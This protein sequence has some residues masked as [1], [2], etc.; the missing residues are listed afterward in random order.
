MCKMPT[1][2]LTPVRVGTQETTTSTHVKKGTPPVR[3]LAHIAQE[4]TY[5]Y[6]GQ[7]GKQQSTVTSGRVKKKPPRYADNRQPEKV[8]STTL[9]YCTLYL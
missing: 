6:S 5:K 9:N 1:P 4:T 8:W 3:I 7:C 2:T